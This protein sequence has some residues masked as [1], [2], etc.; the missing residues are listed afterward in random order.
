MESQRSCHEGRGAVEKK[1]AAEAINLNA[2]RRRETLTGSQRL[3]ERYT[4][5]AGVL[6]RTSLT[7]DRWKANGLRFRR[8]GPNNPDA[9]GLFCRATFGALWT[10]R[11]DAL[12]TV[13]PHQK[14]AYGLTLSR[15]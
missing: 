4:A 5:T 9:S 11:A 8:V 10:F 12:V 2:A 6:S 1:A 14:C 15:A 13:P 3:V 7:F